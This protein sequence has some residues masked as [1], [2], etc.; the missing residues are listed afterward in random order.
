MAMD[1][2]TLRRSKPREAAE[3]ADV[4][5]ASRRAAEAA[6]FIPKSIHTDDETRLWVAAT[7]METCDVW[8]AQAGRRVAA[9]MALDGDTV[10]QLYVAPECQGH[11]VGAMMIKLAKVLSPTRLR[12]FT[13]QSNTPARR[14][15]EAHGFVAID[16]N[17]GSR[18]EEGA[19]DVL[20][21]WTS[22][23]G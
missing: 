14:F 5:L 7:L 17:D 3:V 16:F 18:N 1:D 23:R 21:E 11:G 12:L 19:P 2:V 4:H 15:Y 20:Y 6:G 10:D 22:A 9:M 8:V 13:F